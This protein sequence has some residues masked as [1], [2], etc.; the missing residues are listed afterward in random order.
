MADNNVSANLDDFIDNV[1]PKKM[2]SSMAKACSIVR[3]AAIDKAPH[4]TGALKRSIDFD[5]S[6]NGE[7]GIVY[8]NLDYAPWVEA[9]TGKYATKGAG[10]QTPWV[11]PCYVT[12]DVANK[13]GGEH[14][15]RFFKTEGQK[16][17]P[18]LEPAAQENKSKIIK[19]F[20]GVI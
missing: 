14:G 9:G 11:Y 7:E 12:Q 18:F 4:R 3:N 2:V 19:C 15:L 20:E 8:S 13:I 5:L 16:P 17:K 10:R 6:D 1:L